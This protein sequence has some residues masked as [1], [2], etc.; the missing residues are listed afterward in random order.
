M[1]SCESEQEKPGDK[2]SVASSTFTSNAFLMV[3][4]TC[5]PNIFAVNTIQANWLG[6]CA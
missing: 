2:A 5:P 6:V 3:T 1:T 4:I